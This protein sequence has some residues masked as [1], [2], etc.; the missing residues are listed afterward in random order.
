MHYKIHVYICTVVASFV[1]LTAVVASFVGLTVVVAS[2]VGLT[3]VVAS[4]FCRHH[5]NAQTINKYYFYKKDSF[6]YS[7]K[8]HMLIHGV[9]T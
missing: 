3:A 8:T 6:F 5:W 2:F 7:N 4:L 1:G 9:R